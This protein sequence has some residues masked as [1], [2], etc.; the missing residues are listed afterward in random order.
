MKF[1]RI[2]SFSVACL[3][4]VRAVNNNSDSSLWDDMVFSG[5]SDQ[6]S[7]QAKLDESAQIEADIRNARIVEAGDPLAKN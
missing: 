5:Q 2:V 1:G 4:S 7:D 6:N 3:L